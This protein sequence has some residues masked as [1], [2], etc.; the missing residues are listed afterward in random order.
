M[1]KNDSGNVGVELIFAFVAIVSLVIPSAAKIVEVASVHRLV[2]DTANTAARLWTET[3]S[4]SRSSALE[5]F[6]LTQSELSSRHISIR[7]SCVPSCQASRVLVNLEVSAD[8]DV[9]GPIHVVSEQVFLSGIS[10]T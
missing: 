10:V 7:W 9:L 8:V 5:S 4:D 6:A 3:D 2:T 1:S